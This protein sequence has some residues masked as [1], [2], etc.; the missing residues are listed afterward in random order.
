MHEMSLAVEICRITGEQVGPEGL[1]RVREVGLHVG[2]ESGVEPDALE[3]AL[4]VLLS[5]P[6]FQGARAVLELAP[7]EDLRVSWLEVEDGGPP[8]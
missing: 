6:P 5:E 4:S 2:L 1:H 3:F 8:H 7:G